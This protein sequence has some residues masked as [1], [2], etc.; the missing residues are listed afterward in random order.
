MFIRVSLKIKEFWLELTQPLKEFYGNLS[1][2]KL[3]SL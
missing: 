3:D 1:A 2:L